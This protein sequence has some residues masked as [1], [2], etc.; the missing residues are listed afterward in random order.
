MRSQVVIL[1]CPEYFP[2]SISQTI[3]KLFILLGGID[4]FVKS[5][6]K[7][8]IKPNL[9]SA[10]LPEEGITTHPLLVKEI[11]KRFKDMG[12]KVFLGDS[13]GGGISL[14]EVYEKTGMR[15][16]AQE[17]G[18]ELIKFDKI[19]KIKDY[20]IAEIVFECDR[21]I[22][23]PKFKT[24]ALTT[25]TAGIKNSFGLV[26]GIYKTELHLKYPNPKEFSK[27]LVDI[28]SLR[29]PD[30]VIVDGVVSM[31]GNGPSAGILKKTGFILGSKDA[32]AIDAVLAK[33]IGL[34]PKN[35]STIYEA[36]K[37]GLGEMRGE[38]IEILGESQE[39]ILQKDF[40][41]PRGYS[42]LGI[43]PSSILK[44]GGKLI[45]LKPV[46]RNSSCKRCGVCMNSCPVKAI[47]I[48]DKEIKIDYRIC[49]KCLCCYEFCP[50]KAIY[51]ERG[52][53]LKLLDLVKR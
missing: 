44:W 28:F 47:D 10:S 24:H 7:V 27:V 53:F 50:H 9:L 42:F 2:S 13:P 12:A 1:K 19:R 14:E 37:Q 11:C 38:E 22:S 52:I 31:G 34:N 33:A 3:D 17:L 45:K 43:L 51:L 16:I 36:Y 18:I 6:D 5:Q 4:N 40:P 15:K 20:P 35:I 30:L 41:L 23:L 46:I 48:R 21:F 8:F 29:K 32:V 39:S 25:I 49:I 26:P